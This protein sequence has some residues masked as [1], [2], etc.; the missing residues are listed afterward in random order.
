[1][2][3]NWRLPPSF[4]L[5]LTVLLSGGNEGVADE[6]G[7]SSDRLA[8]YRRHGLDPA[9][10][11]E[12][13]VKGTAAPVLEMFKELGGP[14][15]KAH[16]LTDGERKKLAGA[17]AVLPPLHQRVLRERLRVISFLDGMPN[18][19]L[20]ST[21]NFQ[22]PY[23]LYDITFNASILLQNVS[24]WLTQKERTCFD[25][26]G[27]ALSVNVDAG[28][29]IDALVYVFL[30]EATHVVD[31]CERITPPL[32][33]GKVKPRAEAPPPTSF[34]AGVWTEL[35]LPVPRF[36]DPLRER[37]NF[38][39]PGATIPIGEGP[40][41]YGWLS[42]TPFASL[43]GSRNWL[44]DIAEY[45][46][47]YHL[48]EMLKQP[49]RI[50]IRDAAREVFVHEPMKSGLVRGRIGEIKRFY[51][52]Y[53]AIDR[54]RRPPILKA[55]VDRLSLSPTQ[56]LLM[57]HLGIVMAALFL[58]SNGVADEPVSKY[59][60][61]APKDDGIM[62]TG[63]NDRGDL[64][65]FQWTEE[66]DQPGVVSQVPFYA[67]GKTV[68]NL[69]LLK[70]YTT[71]HPAAISDT[72]LVVGRASKPAPPGPRVYLRNQA[73]IWTEATGIRGLG[74][75]P[76]DSASYA[77]GVTRDGTCISG[78]TIGDGRIRACVWERVGDAWKGT[79]LPLTRQLS[80][81]VVVMSNNGR[82]VASIDGTVP[83]LW[84]RSEQGSRGQ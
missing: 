5:T 27:S 29:T 60:L 58:Q 73:F 74:A 12:S 9:V 30:H 49:Y 59:R 53:G 56:R 63:L 47:V 33:P 13:R 66:K 79:A 1:M 67:R 72:G 78:V 6:P 82:Y 8:A 22:E 75:L 19:A 51:Q 40:A 43:Y 62:A 80:S 83:C 18:T 3:L 61:I 16:V 32:P 65:G 48:T 37:I 36:R 11:L 84:A 21:V 2:K 69:P 24:E 31:A 15:P 17:L 39:A 38:Y 46:A 7:S 54:A 70:G 76:D 41:L 52:G 64:V 57:R 25:T 35:S 68:I 28:T 44:D 26:T 23:R 14:A 77:C 81:Q 20:T 71:T 42:R 55:D 45:V 50:V 10:P 4:V 34:T